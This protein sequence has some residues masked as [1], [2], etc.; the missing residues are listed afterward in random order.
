MSCEVPWVI[1]KVVWVFWA[2]GLL[3]DRSVGGF[4]HDIFMTGKSFMPPYQIS[5]LGY[6]VFWR[7]RRTSLMPVHVKARIATGVLG[8]QAPGPVMLPK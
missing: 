7:C 2:S 1:Y 4:H 6:R 3:R 8:G 5:C